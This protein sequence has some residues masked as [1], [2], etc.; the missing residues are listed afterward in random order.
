MAGRKK[1]AR[2]SLH[3]RVAPQTAEKIKEIAE[4]LGYVYDD[5]GSIGQLLDAIAQGKV[6]LIKAQE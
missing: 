3:A 5:E 1:L 2:T 6:I 4:K